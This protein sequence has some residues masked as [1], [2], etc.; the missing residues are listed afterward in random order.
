MNVIYLL[1]DEL[2][3]SLIG[4][5]L[6]ETLIRE[7]RAIGYTALRLDTGTEQH[8]ALGL[9]RSLGFA[10]IAPYYVVPPEIT[11]WL[12]FMELPL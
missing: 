5:A 12:V 7:A 9:Y 2:V 8:R 3:T 1:C 6:A 11:K 4:R 10:E